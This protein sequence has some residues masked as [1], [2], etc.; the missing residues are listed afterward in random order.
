MNNFLHLYLLAAENN[1][2]LIRIYIFLIVNKKKERKNE[3]AKKKKN[4]Y[5]RVDTTSFR[6]IFISVRQNMKSRKF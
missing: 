6:H 1:L 2:N 5:I 3:I 4:S